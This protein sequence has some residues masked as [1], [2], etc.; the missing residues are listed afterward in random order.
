VIRDGQPDSQVASS[1]RAAAV[2]LRDSKGRFLM[3]K[4]NY[5]LR[6]WGFPGGRV[7]LAETFHQ[8][9]V[10]EAREETGLTVTLTHTAGSL[11]W[12]D[13]GERWEARLFFATMPVDS[14]PSVQDPLEI[15]ELRWVDAE[16]LPAPLTRT[17]TAFFGGGLTP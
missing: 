2:V 17:A 4:E 10:R 11:R 1:Q 12:T 6:R 5:G 15:E 3:I 7:E 13:S 14:F 16:T 8:A 9:A